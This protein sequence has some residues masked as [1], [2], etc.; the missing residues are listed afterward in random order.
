LNRIQYSVAE[1]HE[2]SAPETISDT[3]NWLD[4]NWDLD[5][6][7]DG[8]D[9]WQADIQSNILLDNAVE[10]RKIPPQHNGNGIPN[11]PRLLQL[12]W[13]SKPTV[14]R[15]FMT[16]NSIN[17]NRNMGNEIICDRVCE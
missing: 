17:A 15:I 8:E 7:N 12:T 13:S 9:D 16:F 3:K 4:W 1:R 6:P 5:N 10:D 14:E 2:D 11:F